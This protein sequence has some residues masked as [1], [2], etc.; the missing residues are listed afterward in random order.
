MLIFNLL[1]VN[2]GITGFAILQTTTNFSTQEVFTLLI[3]NV[4]IIALFSLSYYNWE[5]YQ[6]KS[7]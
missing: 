1:I 6:L 5:H 3:F 7:N 4:V 2:G